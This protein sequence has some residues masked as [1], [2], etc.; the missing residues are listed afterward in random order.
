L[1]SW[2]VCKEGRAHYENA[3]LL[4]DI[5]GKSHTKLYCCDNRWYDRNRWVG[6]IVLL[7]C[8]Y[9]RPTGQRVACTTYGSFFCLL[10]FV[11]FSILIFSFFVLICLCYLP[12]SFPIFY[13]SFLLTFYLLINNLPYSLLMFLSNL[14]LYILEFLFYLSH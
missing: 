6:L 11:L 4:T 8:L 3:H 10:V 9:S 2:S 13:S 5:K 12:L 14:L 7:Q 1:Y